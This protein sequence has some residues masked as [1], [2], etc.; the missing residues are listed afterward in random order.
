MDNP[1]LFEFKNSWVDII[2]LLDDEQQG[3]WL[4]WMIENSLGQNP[5]LPDD[6]AVAICCRVCTTKSGQ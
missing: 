3:E 5:N 1:T 2:S 6:T 4:Q